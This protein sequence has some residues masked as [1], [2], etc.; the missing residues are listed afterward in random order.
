MRIINGSHK[1]QEAWTPR[2]DLH[3]Q[4]GFLTFTLKRSQ[5]PIKVAFAMTINKYQGQSL[6]TSYIY[7]PEPIFTHGQ[8]YVALLR[9]ALPDKLRIF[10]RDIPG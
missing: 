1:N 2:I 10:I 5:F 4:D 8:L 9:S 3:T 7:L 6:D